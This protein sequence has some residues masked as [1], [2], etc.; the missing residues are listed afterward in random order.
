MSDNE[1]DNKKPSSI[2]ED[3]VSAESTPVTDPAEQTFGQWMLEQRQLKG[4]SLEEIASVT[5]IQLGMLRSIEA[6]D[7]S[8]LPAPAF[9]RGFIVNF[10]RFV[11]ADEQV[12]VQKFRTQLKKSDNINS[13]SAYLGHNTSSTA[14]SVATAS[15]NDIPR[16]EITQSQKQPGL[17]KNYNRPSAAM[18]MDATPF[19]TP[20]RMIIAGVL[21]VLI[22]VTT[23]LFN[24]GSKQDSEGSVVD[25]RREEIKDDRDSEIL[26]P[27]D[28]IVEA[29]EVPPVP[30]EVVTAPI[31]TPAPPP[32]AAPVATPTPEAKPEP[33]TFTY[34]LK[35]RGIES[36][37]VNVKVDQ[38]G[39]QGNMLERG[40]IKDFY[41]NQRIVV[42]LSDAGGVEIS[43]NGKWYQPA[44]FRGDVKSLTLPED[45]NRLKER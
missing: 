13:L 30:T 27:E 35:L 10:A 29:Q 26:P 22:L 38:K 17:S 32:P 28:Q 12:A 36:S 40:Q 16:K 24:I 9:V 1:Q 33:Q 14:S 37:W 42:S 25:N 15:M 39:S 44:G 23:V 31:P 11:G 45:L 7:Y 6:D 19:L 5:K 4:L 41:G 18:D 3:Q 2:N 43:W 21:I 20:K 8:K 34:H